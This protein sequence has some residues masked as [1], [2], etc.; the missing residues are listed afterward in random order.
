MR[1][2]YRIDNYQKTYFVI[3]SFEQLMDATQPDFAPIYAA[4][5]WCR[6]MPAG[7]VRPVTAC[8]TAAPAKA[9]LKGRM[10]DAAI[11]DFRGDCG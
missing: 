9:G 8:T 7:D 11:V 1:T 6:S 2:R 5:R 4:R 10:P 3:D